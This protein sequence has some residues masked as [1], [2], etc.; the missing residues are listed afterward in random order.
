MI[1]KGLFLDR[2]GVINIDHGYVYRV[3]DFNF[4]DGIFEFTQAAMAK[5]YL[6][7][8][9]TNQAG[10]GRGYYGV[11]DFELLTDWMCKKF[12]DQGVFISGV[13]FS[14]YHPIYGKGIYK[15][16]DISRKPNPGM[17]L[18]AANKFNINLDHST[19]I[20]DKMSDIQAGQNAGVR[21][22]IFL[23]LNNLKLNLNKTFFSVPDLS[24]ARELL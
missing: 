18:Q 9:I 24:K 12:Y 17:I 14:P 13:F 5:G 11:S 15:K 7:F 10:I 2:D 23:N 6:I 4:V 19:L 16:N 3:E 8:V 21:T 1:K 20:G 22:N